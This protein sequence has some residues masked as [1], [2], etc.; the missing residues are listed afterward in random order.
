MTTP[1][2]CCRRY[3]T[4][5]PHV[6]GED[7]RDRPGAEIEC[8]GAQLYHLVEGLLPVCVRVRSRMKREGNEGGCCWV[9][10][11]YVFPSDLQPQERARIHSALSAYHSS[12]SPQRGAS[13]SSSVP[14]QHGSEDPAA[15][16][17]RGILRLSQ[18]PAASGAGS[19][20]LGSQRLS[21]Q[22]EPSAW[23]FLQQQRTSA[24][25]FS[26]GDTTS[27]PATCSLRSGLASTRLSALI[28]AAGALSVELLTAAAY[29]GSTVRARK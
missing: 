18:R 6:L 26:S 22:R 13:Y 14:R 11:Y 21:Q 7:E 27:F 1:M 23:S 24:A 2:A 16:P 8:V 10:G 12:G 28:T 20:P 19:H 25:R 4:R 3:L 15:P 17:A 5:C 29:L 9:G